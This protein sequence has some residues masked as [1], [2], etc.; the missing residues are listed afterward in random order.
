MAVQQSVLSE[1]DIVGQ[2]YQ[3]M[4]V[5]TRSQQDLRAIDTDRM[6]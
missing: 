3:T 6:M 2:L 5:D 1:R 4:P